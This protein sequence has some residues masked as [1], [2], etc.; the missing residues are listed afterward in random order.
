MGIAKVR[1]EVRDRVLY[2]FDLLRTNPQ[3]LTVKDII[4]EIY[5]DFGVKVDRKSI[6]KD[7]DA[8]GLYMPIISERRND[9]KIYWRTMRKEDLIESTN[10]FV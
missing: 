9:K 2:V 10:K 4:N 7:L 8:I 6:Y 5:G 1:L 3:G